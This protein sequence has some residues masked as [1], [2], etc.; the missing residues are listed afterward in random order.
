MGGHG[1]GRCWR[2]CASR[3]GRVAGP[4]SRGCRRAPPEEWV[5]PCRSVSSCARPSVAGGA[6]RAGPGDPEPRVLRVD[7]GRWTR[8]GSRTVC[9]GGRRWRR[10]GTQAAGTLHRRAGPVAKSGAG[11]PGR[12]RSSGGGARLEEL[13]LAA[14]G[15]DRPL[16]GAGKP[17]CHRRAGAAGRRASAAGRLPGQRMLAV[18]VRAASGALAA[19]GPRPARQAWHRSASRCSAA[20]CASGR[21]LHSDAR[22]DGT[23]QAG[24]G[25]PAAAT[26]NSGAPVAPPRLDRLPGKPCRMRRSGRSGAVGA[27]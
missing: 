13:R 26:V 11:R 3:T 27:C 7:G 20:A 9:G 16:D 10:A 23:D 19:A 17:G 2:C 21:R 24:C 12:S 4:A 15:P 1:S 22:P 18:P 5:P 14:V 6:R 8:R 25:A